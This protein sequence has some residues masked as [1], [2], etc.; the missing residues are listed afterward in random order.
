M[1]IY[2]DSDGLDALVAFGKGE[3]WPDLGDILQ[4]DLIEFDT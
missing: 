1:N 3:K 2:Q 4:G